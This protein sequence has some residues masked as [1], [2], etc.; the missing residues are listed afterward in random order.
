MRLRLLVL[1]VR[2]M[3]QSRAFYELLG[4]SF[5]E[6]RHGKGPAHCCSTDLGFPLEL[7]PSAQPAQNYAAL[8]FAVPALQAYRRRLADS[9]VACS[10]ISDIG[11]GPYF[12][13][14]DPDHNRIEIYGQDA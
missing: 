5:A 7:Y 13:V 4:F 2:D 12:V 11:F 8:G 14:R 9:G 6:H 3:A 10:A 1:K